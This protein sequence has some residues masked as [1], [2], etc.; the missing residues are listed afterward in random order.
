MVAV[1]PA[2]GMFAPGGL[3][4]PASVFSAGGVIIEGGAGDASGLAAD[5]GGCCT[6]GFIA[7]G[8]LGD[9]E[10]AAANEQCTIS[11]RE[12]DITRVLSRRANADKR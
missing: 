5:G 12:S 2:A 8:A 1:L 9:A 6:T 11:Q 10:Q 3:G 4:V 7:S